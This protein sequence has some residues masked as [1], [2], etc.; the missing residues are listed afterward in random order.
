ML[1][2]PVAWMV[3]NQYVQMIGFHDQWVIYYHTRYEHMTSLSVL[4]HVQ[5][6]CNL[7]GFQ[8][9]SYSPVAHYSMC[10]VCYFPLFF[11]VEMVEIGP[12]L[13][14]ETVSTIKG[15]I[16]WVSCVMSTDWLI[17]ML[18]FFL[19]MVIGVLLLIILMCLQ[20]PTQ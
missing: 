5:S 13:L 9:P 6:W 15:D 7:F 14:R 1:V 10:L 17:V 8:F 2:V 12:D 3:D 20:F 16:S 18:F 4:N 11:S 19:F